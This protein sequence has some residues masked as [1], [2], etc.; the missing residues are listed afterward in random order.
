MGLPLQLK[1]E[2]FSLLNERDERIAE[3]Q[4]EVFDEVEENNASSFPYYTIDAIEREETELFEDLIQDEIKRYENAK[5]QVIYNYL[6]GL[7]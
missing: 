3:R 1:N 5:N 2:I 4:A 7:V 6:A